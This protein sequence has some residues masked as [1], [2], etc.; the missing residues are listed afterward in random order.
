MTSYLCRRLSFRDHI[1]S[2]WIPQQQDHLQY[3]NVRLSTCV[4]LT[5]E[6][7][8]MDAPPVPAPRHS[9]RQ[10]PPDPPLRHATTK[11]EGGEVTM[12]TIK[13][14]PPP[15]PPPP[16]SVPEIR[17]EPDVKDCVQPFDLDSSPMDIQDASE[18]T[19]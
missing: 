11:L 8:V 2:L 14:P 10:L 4:D 6:E 16:P 5:D 3:D 9:K 17:L 18:M 19:E 13:R 12:T 15:P 7:V 1:I